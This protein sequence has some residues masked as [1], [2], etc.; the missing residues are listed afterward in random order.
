MTEEIKQRIEII[1]A[2]K[3]PVGYKKTQ[4]GVFPDDWV[5]DKTLGD[6]FLFY[7]G[8][9]VSREQ[10]GSKGIAY[11]HYGDMHKGTFKKVSYEQYSLLPK[12]D[13]Q[14]DGNET[15]LMKDG[16]IAFLDASED[17]E[18]TSR[19]VLIDN[20]DNNFFIAG[21]H[22]TLGKSKDD[23]LD[24]WYKQYIT[25]TD[26]V[27]KQFQELAVG[28]KVYGVNRK[29]ITKIVIPCPSKKDEQNRIAKI[30]SKWD[31]AIESQEKLIEKLELQKKALMQKIFIP[32]KEWDERTFK[33]LYDKAGEGGT[34]ST[35]VAKYYD[36]GNIPFIKIEHLSHKYIEEVDSYIT[37]KG[38]ENSGAWLIPEN[39]ILFSN[40]ATIGE[41]AINKIS[42]ATKQGILGIVPANNIDVEFLYYY[43]STSYFLSLVASITT[44]GTMPIVYL[45]DLDKLKIKI[46]PY[47]MQK[48]I[49]QY[50]SLFDNEIA[51]NKEKLKSITQQQKAMQQL[52]LKGIVRV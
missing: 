25:T 37:K 6:M 34:P 38:L 24:K 42:V 22:T 52:L 17:L 47:E 26:V 43:F 1:K 33:S 12:Y 32:S 7:G 10:L 29:E 16:D 5:T 15:F 31:K 45:K 51:L 11:L 3:V 23:F 30:L 18:G 39:C 14:L 19:S 48:K 4:F 46:P 21:L 9:G 20:P 40:G 27:K 8:L 28:F 41:V 36:G 13:I 49:S 35:S 2:G 50:I 44:K